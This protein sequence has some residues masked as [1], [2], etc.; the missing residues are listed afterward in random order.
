[1]ADKKIYIEHEEVDL[2]V[3]G[4]LVLHIGQVSDDDVVNL[5]LY[6]MGDGSIF[7]SIIHKEHPD[8][9][10]THELI[11]SRKEVVANET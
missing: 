9:G 3:D 8:H 6:P 4:Q 10:C 5:F 11:C 1:M 2:Y 7:E